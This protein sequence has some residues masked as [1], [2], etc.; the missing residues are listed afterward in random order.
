MSDVTVADSVIAPEVSAAPAVVVTQFAFMASFVQTR[1]EVVMSSP[2][3]ATALA[4]C[5]L[6]EPMLV[7]VTVSGATRGATATVTVKVSAGS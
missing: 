3:H 1:N 5:A 2:P 6:A 4:T 7:T